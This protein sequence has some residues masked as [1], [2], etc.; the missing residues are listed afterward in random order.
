[1]VRR[2][3]L[4]VATI[5]ILCMIS[6]LFIVQPLINAGDQ[7]VEKIKEVG[8]FPRNL[9][10]RGTKAANYQTGLYTRYLLIDKN[11]M[12][13]N[14]AQKDSWDADRYDS[15][16]DHMDL[17]QFVRTMYN[18]SFV[19]A[20]IPQNEYYIIGLPSVSLTFNVS[21][22]DAFAKFRLWFTVSL[23]RISPGGTWDQ[24]I[25]FGTAV[26]YYY[27]GPF[28]YEVD[29]YFGLWFAKS[30]PNPV[31]I[32]PHEKIALK[33]LVSGYSEWGASDVY[34]IHSFNMSKPNQFVVDLPIVEP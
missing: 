6:A 28:S 8:T 33:I 16:S 15:D 5:A 10:L 25:D 12:Y 21:C 31:W 18:K 7:N 19:Y 1:M 27:A 34:L 24:V 9:V 17:N 29:E 30:T 32:G 13:P 3:V 14:P 26:K 20:K 2:R 11:T 22:S 4:I 23:W